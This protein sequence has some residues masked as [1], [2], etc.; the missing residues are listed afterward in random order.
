MMF[1]CIFIASFFLPLLATV[2]ASCALPFTPLRPDSVRVPVVNSPHAHGGI[3]IKLSDYLHQNGHPVSAWQAMKLA[4][5]ACRNKHASTLDIGKGSY[6]F[7]DP[8]ILTSKAE[9][10]VV[11]DGLS[12]LTID[13]H[14]AELDF[15]HILSGFQIS[16]CK[17]VMIKNLSVDWNVPLAVPGHIIRDAE[18][19]KA[20]Q[21][22]PGYFY[23][24]DGKVASVSNFDV[25][26]MRWDKSIDFECYTPAKVEITPETRSYYI[27]EIRNYDPAIGA[28]CVIRYHTYDGWVFCV[29]PTSSD[30]TFEHVNLYASPGIG[31][32]CLGNRGYKL[33][34]CNIEVKPGT[35]RPI[36]L[37]SDGI[38]C[39]NT[40]GDI[41]LDHCNFSGQGDDA[42]NLDNSWI[43]ISSQPDKRT[44]QLQTWASAFW[45]EVVSRGGKALE[46]GDKISFWSKKD[47]AK[48]GD[49]MVVKKVDDKSGHWIVTVDRDLPA[50]ATLGAVVRCDFQV[51]SGFSITNCH[52][53]NSRAR[54]MVVQVQDGVIEN[55]TVDH[56]CGSAVQLTCDTNWW[57][58]GYGVHNVV[59]RGNTFRSC[60]FVKWERTHSGRHLACLSISSNTLDGVSPFPQQ[61]NLLIDNNTIDDTPG[62]AIQV[63]S[64]QN[65]VV[66]RNTISNANLEPFGDAG[67]DSKL[68]PHGAIFV[69]YSS[70]VVVANNRLMSSADAYDHGV[71]VDVAS[72][73][74]IV[75]KDN[76]ER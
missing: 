26:H 21:V 32:Y 9:A 33:S 39:R 3:I 59:V 76:D 49:A 28:G 16:H 51:T 24:P 58:E 36:S 48:L 72:T 65:V 2:P 12:D 52:F 6:V 46:P 35:N 14:G 56:T 20:V 53:H 5:D 69:A 29:T 71:G 70:N 54:G 73:K 30:I 27:Q 64:A 13:G 75:V 47:L 50:G 17:R 23:D 34:Y 31:W 1:R 43:T 40:I 55:N 62:L 66:S 57:E 18:G 10:N 15:H 41:I 4:L 42:V 63:T 44:L 38:Q 8:D 7:N 74:D 25:A 19:R 67:T 22:D 45:T 11:I 61:T 37:M 60:N 68:T